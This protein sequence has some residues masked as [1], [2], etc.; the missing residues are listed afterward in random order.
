[1]A[2]GLTFHIRVLLATWFLKLNRSRSRP[3]PRLFS[4]CEDDDE[5]E[6]E[7]AFA[8]PHLCVKNKSAY[9]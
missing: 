3:R 5:V 6:D 4:G 1:M 9:E 7:N 8:S 2:V